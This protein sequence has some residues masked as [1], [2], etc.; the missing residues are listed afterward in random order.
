MFELGQVV[1]TRPALAFAEANGVD[2]V[3]LLRRHH[4]GDWGEL[5]SHDKRLNDAA[6]SSGEDRVFSAYDACGER[7]YIITEWDRSSTC[8]MLARDY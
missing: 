2:V 6:V 1:I 8:V 5:D 4:G 7:F 3:G